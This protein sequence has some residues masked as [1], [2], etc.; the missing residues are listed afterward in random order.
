MGGWGVG[1]MCGGGMGERGRGVRH[2]DVVTVGL[3]F[4]PAVSAV[5]VTVAHV[6]C[7]DADVVAALDLSNWT[8]DCI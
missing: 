8:L 4:V 5:V 7:L 3:N 2:L 1:I 6:G